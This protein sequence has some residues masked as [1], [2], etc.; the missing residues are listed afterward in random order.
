MA[1]DKY[2]NNLDW[3]TYLYDESPLKEKVVLCE[4]KRSSPTF[5]TQNDHFT[6]TGS[7]LIGKGAFSAGGEL[8]LYGCRLLQL[9]GERQEGRHPGAAGAKNAHLLRHF[10][11]K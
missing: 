3:L 10:M 8:Q 6:K 2:W 9:R 11:L 4:R 7:G 5:Y 1:P